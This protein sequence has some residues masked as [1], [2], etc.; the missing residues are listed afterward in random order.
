MK[1]R[2][3]KT[4]PKD[5]PVLLNI[6]NCAIEGQWDN[7]TTTDGSYSYGPGKWTVVSLS[8]HGCGCCAG[9]NDDPTGWA[10]LPA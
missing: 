10:P 1:W 3:M 6:E 8:S 5:K 7:E 4:A 2:D 9:D